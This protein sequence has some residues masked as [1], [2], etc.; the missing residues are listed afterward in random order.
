MT[1]A[2]YIHQAVLA[3]WGK[4][5]KPRPQK[6]ADKYKLAATLQ[7]VA[8]QVKKLGVNVNQ[9]AKQANN[10]MV[11]VTRAEVHYLLN[12]HQMLMSRAIAAIERV[13]A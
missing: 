7:H 12:Q 13:L 5:P 8:F 3:C 6:N 4:E 1:E 2:S 11:P 10:G 9:L